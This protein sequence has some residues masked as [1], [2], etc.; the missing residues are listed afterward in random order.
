[1]TRPATTS[2]C[3][4]RCRQPADVHGSDRPGE[5]VEHELLHRRC[6]R[7]AHRARPTPPRRSKPGRGP[8]PRAHALHDPARFDPHLA[9]ATDGMAIVDTN[10]FDAGL[11]R[12]AADFNS[13]YLLGYTSTNGKPDGKYRKIRVT[14]KRPGVQVRAR[15]GY[16]ARRADELPAAGSS[17]TPRVLARRANPTDAQLTAALGRLTPPRPDMPLVV[18]AAAGTVAGA[19]RDRS[20]SPPSSTPQSPRPP[21]GPKA[22]RRRPPCATRRATPSR[23]GR[24]RWRRGRGRWRSR[25]PSSRA[26][27]AT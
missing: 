23:R 5:P 10:D 2:A 4:P 18:S 27:P 1:M 12:A 13:Y 7:P 24:P 16:L 6:G 26:W 22:A 19:R 11:R 14:V 15:E 8:Q 17:R 9:E 3:R 20:A 21:N 25:C